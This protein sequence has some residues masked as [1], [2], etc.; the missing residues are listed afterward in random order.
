[1][2]RCRII[3]TLFRLECMRKDLSQVNPQ[4]YKWLSIINERSYTK[5]NYFYVLV[6]YSNFILYTCLRL[7]V[8]NANLPR[9]RH[10]M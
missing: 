10:Y 8:L 2:I 1:M 7:L 9:L 6:L 5:K 3:M 4:L